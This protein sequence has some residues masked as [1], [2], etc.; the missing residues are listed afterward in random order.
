MRQDQRG[1]VQACRDEIKEAK[2]QMELNLARDVKVR[3]GF[4]K[5]TKGRPGE[6]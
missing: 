3:N 4:H 1:I 5:L 2:D 6:M